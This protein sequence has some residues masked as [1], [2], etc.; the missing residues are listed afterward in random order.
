MST[1]DR[2]L[3]ELSSLYISREHLSEFGHGYTACHTSV[4]PCCLSSSSM[5]PIIIFHML[6]SSKVLRVRA[7]DN[8]GAGEGDSGQVIM[9]VTV[10]IMMGRARVIA[11]R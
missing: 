3:G 5:L 4:A 1:H 7:G 9:M 2:N 8:D 11:G 6:D 10:V